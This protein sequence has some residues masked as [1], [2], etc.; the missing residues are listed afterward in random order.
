MEDD[1]LLVVTDDEAFA[2]QVITDQ[3]WI[4]D[5]GVHFIITAVVRSRTSIDGRALFVH[6]YAEGNGDS[7]SE[8]GS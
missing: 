3:H 5:E 2:D 8:N 4:D 6:G 1:P 7:C